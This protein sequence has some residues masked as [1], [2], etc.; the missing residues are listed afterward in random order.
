MSR[1][2]WEDPASGAPKELRDWLAKVIARSVTM[3]E[4]A[5]R[6]TVTPNDVVLVLKQMGRCVAACACALA[7]SGELSA[8]ALLLA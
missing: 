8:A 7:S 3:A 6:M 2:C 1:T 4:H 5:R